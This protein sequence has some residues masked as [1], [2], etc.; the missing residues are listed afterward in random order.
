MNFF[1][2]IKDAS[3]SRLGMDSLMGVEIQ[4]ILERYVETTIL[5]YCFLSNFNS[6]DYDFVV[7]SQEMR[8]LTL[9]QLEKRV[10]SKNSEVAPSDSIE[11]VLDLAL[12]MT[13]FGSEAES[14]K[15]ILKL[16]SASE[17]DKTKV[18]IIPGIEGMAGDIWIEIAKKMRHPTYILQ[19]AK[20]SEAT[21]INEIVE[22]VSKV[23][24]K[25]I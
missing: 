16:E 18:L 21:D 7:S 8:S 10:S 14:D 5:L 4:Q 12:L 25:S 13:G 17:E 2:I 9:S 22:F 19:L 15:T 1:S 20:T 3:L 6:S 11:G 23:K 24:S